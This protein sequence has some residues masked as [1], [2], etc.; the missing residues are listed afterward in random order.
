M[1]AIE[2]TPD[3][4]RNVDFGVGDGVDDGGEDDDDISNMAFNVSRP[5]SRHFK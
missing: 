1:L 2:P 3:V 5:K 4:S